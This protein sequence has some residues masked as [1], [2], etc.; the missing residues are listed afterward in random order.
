MLTAAAC[1][2]T[3]PTCSS[4]AAGTRPG[5]PASSAPGDALE[6]GRNAATSVL[7]KLAKK[8]EDVEREVLQQ[9]AVQVWRG[10]NLSLSGLLLEG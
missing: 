5:V 1:T 2:T 3:A 4:C 10:R 8:N 9:L 6:E 7:L